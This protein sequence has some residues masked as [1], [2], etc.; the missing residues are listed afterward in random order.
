[1]VKVSSVQLNVLEAADND[2]SIYSESISLRDIK[3]QIYRVIFGKI[4]FATFMKKASG[5]GAYGKWGAFNGKIKCGWIIST[6]WNAMSLEAP[7]SRRKR[8]GSAKN[9]VRTDSCL[10]LRLH[11]V[12]RR[13]SSWGGYWGA[14][15]LW[16]WKGLP[17][18]IRFYY[19]TIDLHCLIVL[20][21]F[22]T[23]F[24]SMRVCSEAIT[25]SFCLQFGLR[26]LRSL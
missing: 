5:T 1:M 3:G 10:V 20:V 19:T 17:H 21:L 25:L 12:T 13:K 22:L 6:Q 4:F 16:I 23:N 18:R 24:T 15:A 11:A 14:L 26:T 8:W 9:S 2:L 7:V